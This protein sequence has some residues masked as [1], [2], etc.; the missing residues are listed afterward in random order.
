VTYDQIRRV[1]SRSLTHCD[2]YNWLYRFLFSAHPVFAY[3]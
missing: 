3:V 2:V 1:Q